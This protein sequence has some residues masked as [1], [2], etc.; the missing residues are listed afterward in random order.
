MLASLSIGALG[1]I[2]IGQDVEEWS[3][4]EWLASSL[5]ALAILR[6]FLFCNARPMSIGAFFCVWTVGVVYMMVVGKLGFATLKSSA[7]GIYDATRTFMDAT[8]ALFAAWAT[9]L[10]PFASVCIATITPIWKVMSLQQRLVAVL[11]GFS[12]WGLL[13][14]NKAMATIG[15]ALFQASFLGVAV[16]CAYGL[17]QLPPHALK[18]LAWWLY[19]GQPLLLSLFAIRTGRDW[20]QSA[21][22][23]Y[24]TT[25][26]LLALVFPKWVLDNKVLSEAQALGQLRIFIVLLLWLQ[27]YGGGATLW[28][29]VKLLASPLRTLFSVDDARTAVVE[30]F[31][32]GRGS[33]MRALEWA[34]QHKQLALGGTLV[35]LVLVTRVAAK[36]LHMLILFAFALD[37][38]KVASKQPADRAGIEEKLAFWVCAATFKLATQLLPVVKV[39]LSPFGGEILVLIILHLG[40][41][42]LVLWVLSLARPRQHTD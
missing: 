28:A 15:D 42:K 26:P 37:S 16:V 24:W 6:L 35:G 33:A 9:F 34:R 2:F 27:C 21:Q 5:M 41:S 31:T 36:G 4:E 39:V 30:A 22:L 13:G 12:T 20:W 7:V 38:L 17:P 14:N 23:S 25:W 1:T 11:G 10:L 40:G 29:L 32:F 18:G 8:F 19:L 3:T